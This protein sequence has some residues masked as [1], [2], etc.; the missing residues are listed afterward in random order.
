MPMDPT[1]SLSA[2]QSKAPAVTPVELARAILLFQ[3]GLQEMRTLSQRIDGLEKTVRQLAQ[4]GVHRDAW[5]R[6][7]RDV[8]RLRDE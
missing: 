4:D 7:D 1:K 5:Q 2:D 8:A 3:S 6:L